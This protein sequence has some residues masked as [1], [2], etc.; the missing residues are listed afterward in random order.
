M[1]CPP[2]LYSPAFMTSEARNPYMPSVNQNQFGGPNFGFRT[3]MSPVFQKNTK[4]SSI[5]SSK[6]TVCGDQRLRKESDRKSSATF[7]S[8]YKKKGRSSRKKHK[9]NDTTI[10]LDLSPNDIV[11]P[12]K[13]HRNSQ[14]GRFRQSSKQDKTNSNMKSSGS[15]S[16]T[17]DSQSSSGV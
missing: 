3:G 2:E 15:G 1:N 14:S 7:L 6:F 13:I 4:Q 5:Y 12:D 17:S 11:S 10:K 8:S 16:Y 9:A